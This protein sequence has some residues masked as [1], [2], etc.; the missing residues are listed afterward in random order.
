MARPPTDPD[1]RRERAH[2]VLD[3]AAELILR[4]GYDKTTIADV[5]RAAGVAKGTIYLHWKTREL[6]FA[7]L[8]RRER[9]ATLEEVRRAAPGT[10]RE[11]VGAVA[12]EV[13]RRPLM[14]AV[15]LADTDV[16]GRLTTMKSDR[17]SDPG[18]AE[19]L[20][21]LLGALRKHGAIRP[22]LTDAEHVSVL[23]SVV[24]GFLTAARLTPEPYRVPP[25]RLA[26]LLADTA[27]RALE[28]GREPSPRE[29]RAIAAAVSAYVG[30]AAGVAGRKL[31]TALEG[32]LP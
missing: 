21:R 26:E 12:A 23:T 7:A 31:E 4:W 15:L 10:L 8:L 24:F 9:V 16:L 13:M 30:H 19:A 25:E 28:A 1:R 5:A 27:H 20:N 22:D 14:R 29:A 18:Q 2:R 17:P 11:L 3:A 32:Q 6:L